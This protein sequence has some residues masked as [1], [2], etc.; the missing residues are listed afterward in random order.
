LPFVPVYALFYTPYLTALCGIHKIL[1]LLTNSKRHGY[2]RTNEGI[3][4]GRK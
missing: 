2:C 3:F 4:R 1:T